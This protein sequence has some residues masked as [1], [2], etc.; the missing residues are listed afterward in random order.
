MPYVACANCGQSVN[1][2]I[3][4]RRTYC[5]A[6]HPLPL[7]EHRPAEK[8]CRR[9]GQTKFV[10]EF[11]VKEEASGLRQAFCKSCFNSYCLTVCA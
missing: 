3:S 7:G 11:Y 9:C 2:P 5:P 6:C 4:Q 1:I 8:L 10:S